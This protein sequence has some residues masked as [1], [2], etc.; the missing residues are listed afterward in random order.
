LESLAIDGGQHGG[1]A[2]ERDL[3]L[4]GLPAKMSPRELSLAIVLL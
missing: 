2:R 3:V 1:R 4:A